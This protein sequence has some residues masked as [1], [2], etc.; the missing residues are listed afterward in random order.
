MGRDTTASQR[1]LL[2]DIQRLL[3]ILLLRDVADPRFAGASITRVESSG[4]QL[5][6]VWVYHM[7]ECDVEACMQALERMTPHFEHE[8]RHALAKRHLPRLRFRWDEAF[9]KSGDV[10]QILRDLESS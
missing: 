2:T 4:R 1:R 9:E 8:L 7:G 6:T 10:L 5:V 3:S